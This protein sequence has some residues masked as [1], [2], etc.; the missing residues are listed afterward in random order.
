MI[1]QQKPSSAPYNNRRLS[2]R[3]SRRPSF[4]ACVGYHI[5]IEK[6]GQKC[7]Y[8]KDAATDGLI[9]FRL[10]RAL[11]Y[12]PEIDGLRAVAVIPVILFH[13]G[14]K[15]FSGGFIGVDVF[16][17]IS[18][19]LITSIIIRDIEAGTFS[20]AGFYERRARRI[21]P[22]LFV[23]MLCCLPFAWMWL[24][25]FDLKTFST[26][27]IS[28]CLFASN[29]LFWRQSGYFDTASE[30]KPLLHTWSL[31][32]EEQFYI[33]FPIMLI[34][35]FRFARGYLTPFIA[36]ATVSSLA[37]SDYLSRS[38][39]D[40]N[41]FWAPTRA[42]ELGLG[43]LCSLI[44]PAPR[45]SLD[46]LISGLGLIAVIVSLF[47]FDEES[48]M[49]SLYSLLPVLGVCAIILFAG[50][51]TVVNFML[52]RKLVVGIGLVSYSA[53][54]IHQPLFAFARWRSILPLTIF[55]VTALIILTFIAAYL[56]WRF[57][58]FP[59]RDKKN[60]PFLSRRVLVSTSLSFISVF[61]AFGTYGDLTRGAPDRFPA[62]L[63]TILKGTEDVGNYRNDC[64]NGPSA[65]DDIVPRLCHLGAHNDHTDFVL[66]GDSYA[67]A[68][69]DGVNA[70]AIAA[71]KSGS[72]FGL[73]LCLPI[74]AIGG[75]WVETRDRCKAFQRSMLSIVDRLKPHT[76]ILHA[77]WRLLDSDLLVHEFMPGAKTG[78]EAF[79]E[80]LVG[81]IKEFR[82][83]DI[84]VY[85]VCCTTEA[86]G[87]VYIP[88]SLAKI[89]LYGSPIDIRFTKQ[90]FMQTNSTA[91]S[92]FSSD[93]V[94]RYATFIDLTNVFCHD[95]VCD[96]VQD[97]KPL[98]FDRG[99]LSKS[100]SLAL[101]PTLQ[102][103]FLS[104]AGTASTR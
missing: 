20:F 67:G 17:V 82:K 98:F 59:W 69:A 102:S 33:F 6:N 52:S 37:L 86:V 35:L 97:N 70:A 55:Q 15:A 43:S 61:F 31:A 101:V 2:P 57:I 14:F 90:Q 58:E 16:F 66:F 75:T 60:F 26:S 80:A 8:A 89:S 48:R 25:P 40:F 1:Y 22:A 51:G 21:L 50:A 103:I 23:V 94:R 92:L 99:H 47:L 32:V 38:H 18:G 34:V 68:I 78:V 24:F 62:E 46:N 100:G 88:Q 64:L 11:K 91:F 3:A 12:R 45:R 54:L 71:N 81:T 85:I 87:N 49:P 53:Y 73:H 13:A 41:F 76:V 63:L 93:E 79:H 29:I 56:S 9:G 96:L 5:S 36:I 10:D 28:V 74:I 39:A 95:E 44:R 84:Q 4:F 65:T 104:S 72:L 77:A 7:V 42:W 27:L 30:L 83:R 19:Y